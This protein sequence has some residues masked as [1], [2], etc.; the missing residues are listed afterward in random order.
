M[1]LSYGRGKR[2]IELPQSLEWHRLAFNEH[3]RGPGELRVINGAVQELALHIGNFDFRPKILLLL[4]DHTRRCR[5]QVILP[6]VLKKLEPMVADFRILIA[7]GTHV[8]QPESVI[9]ELVGNEVYSKNR[10]EQHDCHDKT[11]LEYVGRTN[12]C[13][14]IWLNRL[15][16]QADLILTING[17][18]YHYFAGFG[19]GAKMLM[20]GAAGYETTRQNHSYVIDRK[21]GHFHKGCR[22]GN[23]DDNPVYQDLIQVLQYVPPVL[24]L[25]VVLNR[26]GFVQYA[27]SGPLMPVH[28]YLR[29]RV[30][31]VY[32]VPITQKADIVVGSAGGYPADVNFIQSHKSLHHTFMAVREGGHVVLYAACDQGIGSETILPYFKYTALEEM[33][34]AML[35]NYQVNAHTALA[36]RTKVENANIYLISNLEPS[37]VQRTGMIPVQSFARAFAKIKQSDSVSLGYI[38]DQASLQ[39]PTLISA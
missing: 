23:L 31:K 2:N 28:Q 16:L 33:A 25:Q 34:T 19:G 3:E 38:M 6:L 27:K 20:P 32:S 11:M 9:K 36:I 14:P 29:S 22:E 4:P 30:E 5:L 10:I 18:L 37:F 8:L 12:Y 39:V 7:N 17:I 1:F 35:N 13:T 15:L 21:S 26:K 24:S